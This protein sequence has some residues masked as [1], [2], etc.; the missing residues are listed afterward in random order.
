MG[1]TQSTSNINHHQKSSGEKRVVHKPNPLTE[2]EILMRIEAPNESK[3][4]SL[5]GVNFNYAWV[6]QRGYYPEGNN[7]IFSFSLYIFQF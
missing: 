2:S 4:L 1:C 6:S 3:T 5:D 7:S